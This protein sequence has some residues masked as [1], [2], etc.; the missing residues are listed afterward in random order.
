MSTSSDNKTPSLSRPTGDHWHE[1]TAML[2]PDATDV[3]AQWLSDDLDELADELAQFASPR[4]IM[5]SI[6]R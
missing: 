2:S 4:S 5:K 6:S 1:L 3:F